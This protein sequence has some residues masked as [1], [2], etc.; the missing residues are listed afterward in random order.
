MSRDA[1]QKRATP[2]HP[3]RAAAR[4]RPAR[5]LHPSLRQ[6]RRSWKTQI[7]ADLAEA[8]R[9]AGVSDERVLEAISATPRAGYVPGGYH[10]VACCDQLIPVGHDQVTTQPPLSARIIESLDLTGGDH[11]LEIGIGL[12]Y[13]TALLARL[14][15]DVVSIERWPDLADQVRQNLARHGIRNV[16]VLASDGSRVLPDRAAMTPP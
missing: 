3:R 4:E 16:E 14:A 6:P 15:A 10:R 11:L 1:R 8:T 9:A 2:L 5:H 12:G 13:Q 7:A